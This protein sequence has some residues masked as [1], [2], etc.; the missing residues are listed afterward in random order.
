MVTASNG[1]TTSIATI[2]HRPGAWPAAPAHPSSRQPYGG[3]QSRLQRF[4][5][6]PPPLGHGRGDAPLLLQG[7]ATWIFRLKVAGSCSSEPYIVQQKTNTVTNMI[8]SAINSQ[9]PCTQHMDAHQVESLAITLT[10]VDCSHL[11]A[12]VPA[13]KLAAV[14]ITLAASFAVRLVGCIRQLNI[15]GFAVWSASDRAASWVLLFLDAAT[16]VADCTC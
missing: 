5:P 2:A 7:H 11:E 9:G 3:L 14:V 4:T 16:V 6:C 12:A 8:G 1:Q 15:L 13:F 10:Q